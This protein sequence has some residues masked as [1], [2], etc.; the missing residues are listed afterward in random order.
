[1]LLVA[2]EHNLATKVGEGDVRKNSVLPA[3]HFGRIAV[4]ADKKDSNEF[5][6]N[7]MLCLKRRP[8]KILE[9]PKFSAMHHAEST[10]SDADVYNRDRHTSNPQMLAA[11]KGVEFHK[12]VLES[13][14]DGM[15]F[16]PKDALV[17]MDFSPHI[18]CVA[19][20]MMALQKEHKQVN[21][22]YL[23]FSC[24]N[25]D[26]AYAQERV[27]GEVAKGWLSGAWQ[28]PDLKPDS[29]CPPLPDHI[30]KAIPGGDS[31]G[32]DL[33]KADWKV[34]VSPSMVC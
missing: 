22:Y 20:A 3:C 13:V 33:S 11:Q 28:H 15:D 27:A 10:S 29:V 32:G 18:G 12:G 8:N 24:D 34:C 31:A 7:S 17:V 2:R 14:I 6:A 23:G 19:L 9:L 4:Q 26:H 5:L 21:L 30:F 25:K 16:T 1:L